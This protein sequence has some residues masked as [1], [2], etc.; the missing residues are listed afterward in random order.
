MPSHP[1]TACQSWFSKGLSC[2]HRFDI[3]EQNKNIYVTSSEIDRVKPDVVAE[4]A[5]SEPTE[6]AA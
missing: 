6:E 5:L 4:T 2:F 1:G 3:P